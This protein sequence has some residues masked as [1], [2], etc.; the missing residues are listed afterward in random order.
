MIVSSENLTRGRVFYG[1]VREQSWA[2]PHIQKSARRVRRVKAG[3]S[4]TQCLALTRLTRSAIDR[5]GG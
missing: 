2:Y 1:N 4:R 3:G 5:E